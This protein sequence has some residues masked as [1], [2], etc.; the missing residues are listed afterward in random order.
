MSE[1]FE[2][3][4]KGLLEVIDLVDDKDLESTRYKLPLMGGQA[5]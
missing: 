5:A 2:S 4:A 3:I 1:A